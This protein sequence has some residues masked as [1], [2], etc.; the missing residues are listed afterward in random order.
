LPAARTRREH[1]PATGTPWIWPFYS[2]SLFI[3]LTI[4]LAIRSWWLT[5][6]FEPAKGAEMC[7]RPYFLF[8]LIVAWSVLIVE[9]GRARDSEGAIA[10]GMLLPLVALL[11]GF[12]GPAQ[13]S[14]ELAFLNRLT[15]ALGSPPQLVM[16]G[17]LLF[18]GWAWLRRVPAAEG[19]VLVLG[20]FSSVLHRTTF[21]LYSLG[22]PG[23]LVL[24]AIAAL[25]LVQ[26]I[27]RESTW[28]AIAAAS[29]IVAA[30]R[31]AG[32]RLGG[33]SVWFWQW[34]A[35]LA[36]ALLLPAVFNDPLAKQLRQL[37]WRLTPA[38]AVVTAAVYPFVLTSLPQSTFSGYL[39]VLLMVSAVLWHREREA[40]P[41]AATGATLAANF[42]AHA[43]QIYLLLGQTPLADGLPWL[44]CG[45]AVVLVALVISLL[46]M[47][48][49][50]RVWHWLTRLNLALRGSPP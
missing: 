2:W 4:G 28:R 16:G 39:A 37:A 32:T 19:F 1:E 33:E 36:A 34:H 49:W 35:P 14:V 15:A 11:L 47:G 7:F 6:S 21:D 18:Y 12:P 9:M 38:I 29:L 22:P 17:L 13:N 8:P 20:L 45:L 40:A 23:P 42:L 43:R 30:V 48:L 5:I 24:A 31:F 50:P 41:L 10:A 3:Y 26:A 25:L 27:R 44:A 46:K